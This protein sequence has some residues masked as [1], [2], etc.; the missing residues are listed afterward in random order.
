LFIGSLVIYFSV[1]TSID[2]I[3]RDQLRILGDAVKSSIEAPDEAPHEIP[4]IFRTEDVTDPEK[5]QFQLFT[6]SKKLMVRRGKLRVTMPLNP[7]AEFETQ[8]DPHA[9]LLTKPLQRYGQFYGYLRLATTLADTDSYKRS[10]FEGLILGTVTAALAS[11]L[12]IFWLVRQSLKPVEHS[13]KML[14]DFT[15]DASHELKTPLTA[16]KTNGAVALK[17]DQGMRAGDKEKITAILSAANQMNRTLSDLLKLAEYDNDVVNSETEELN[18]KSL[19]S[20][21]TGELTELSANKD[22][23]IKTVVDDPNLS[24]KISKIDANLLLLNIIKNAVIYSKQNEKV[25]V[26]AKRTEKAIKFE[27]QDR[28]IGIS[29]QDIGHI[30]ERFWRADKART[31]QSGGNGLGLSIA[32]SIVERNNGTISVESTANEGSKFSVVLPTV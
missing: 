11:L 27:I 21:I 28:G 17:Y 29:Q 3:K 2:T 30:F 20:E 31:Y 15:A 13:I 26:T 18:V 6:P 8:T 23:E 24:I 22:V 10:L 32:K 19:L 7:D 16:I 1:A 9:L 12:A 25:L 4:D 5:E 14:K